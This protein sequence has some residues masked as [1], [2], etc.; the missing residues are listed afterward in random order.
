V[1]E[2][3]NSKDWVLLI[4]NDTQFAVDFTQRLVDIARCQAPAVIGS[5][6]CNEA[7][8]DQ[9][10][11]IGAVIDTWR[12]R[13]RD[14]LTETRLRNLTNGLH[15][16]DAL[17]GRGTLYPLC[18]FRIAG[19]MK[20]LWLP[21]YFA[22]YELSVRVGKA[23]F[24]LLVTEDAAILSADEFGNSYSPTGLRDK[25]FSIRSAYYL[26]AVM[27]FW[28]CTSSLLERLTLLPRLI[29]VSLKLRRTHS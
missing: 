26:P 20:P 5:I 7:A 27:A 8:P 1:L 4:N 21:H 23:G 12:L 11:S 14:K 6:I 15:S 17:S 25:F 3:G 24:K 22:D 19:T 29:F 13:V 28:W 16:V 18:A 9:L 10:L 2:E